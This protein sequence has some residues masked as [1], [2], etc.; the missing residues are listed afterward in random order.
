MT[1]R[2]CFC[3][4]LLMVLLTGC[5]RGT[6]S[7][8]PARRKGLAEAGKGAPAGQRWLVASRKTGVGK[9]AG[10]KKPD[11]DLPRGTVSRKGSETILTLKKGYIQSGRFTP[12]GKGMATAAAGIYYHVWPLIPG[13]RA[14]GSK[15]G[16]SGSYGFATS[17][18]LLVGGSFGGKIILRDMTTFQK[19]G[20]LKGHKDDANA[21][22]FL[23]PSLLLSGADDRR[24]LLWDLVGRRLLREVARVES[25]VSALACA[26]DG[27]RFAFGTKDGAVYLGSMAGKKVVRLAAPG[28]SGRTLAHLASVIISLAFSRDGKRLAAASMLAAK[29]Q[30]W[31]VASGKAVR[32]ITGAHER[33]VLSV[34]FTARGRLLS[35]GGDNRVR[36]WDLSTGKAVKAFPVGGKENSAQL[37]VSPDGRRY[38]HW[39]P[40]ADKIWI[41]ALP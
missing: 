31:D 39:S 40:P 28:P 35:S 13:G 19:R 8:K 22:C 24:V 1:K 2:I 12:D 27:R 41:R 15:V 34:A 23:T 9:R 4:L 14:R 7:K 16:L 11:P 18:Q 25:P 37:T 6:G 38:A 29:I 20:T 26:R 36:L 30:V 21:F 32:T 5:P 17:R 33:S 10:S 3:P